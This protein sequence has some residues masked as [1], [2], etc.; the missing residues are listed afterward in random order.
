[1]QEPWRD[2][3]S[4]ARLGDVSVSIASKLQRKLAERVKSL[5]EEE[6]RPNAQLSRPRLVSPT[7]ARRD[8]FE[9]GSGLSSV[10]HMPQAKTE[11]DA[12]LF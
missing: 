11:E 1:M 8:I 7:Y 12:C 5:V 10:N 2:L 9:Q 6:L 4:L 3:R